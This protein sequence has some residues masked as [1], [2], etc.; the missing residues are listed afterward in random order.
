MT[1]VA[2]PRGWKAVA[3]PEAIA[4]LPRDRKGFPIPW[5]AEWSSRVGDNMEL[6]HGGRVVQLNCNC[7]IGEGVPMLGQQCPTRQRRCMDERLCQV[8]SLPIYGDEDVYFVGSL[9]GNVFWEPPLHE[10]CARYSLQVCPGITRRPGVGVQATRAYTL[11][12]KFDF[13]PDD[14]R[15]CT[16]MPH[17]QLP[18]AVALGFTKAALCF[19]GAVPTN[20]TLIPAEEFLR[21]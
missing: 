9:D 20:P 11:H 4:A 10:Q 16:F 15:N 3:M 5:V 7:A 8:C 18:L 2:M 13:N 6:T 12:D 1:E 14:Q 17:G 19:R 21:G